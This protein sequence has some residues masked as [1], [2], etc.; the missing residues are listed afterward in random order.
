[1]YVYALITSPAGVDD[2]LRCSASSG[3]ALDY[4]K[5]LL[6]PATPI[7]VSNNPTYEVVVS[8]AKA[9]P[10]WDLTLGTAVGVYPD[11]GWTATYGYFGT[12]RDTTKTAGRT[13]FY[14]PGSYGAYTMGNISCTINYGPTTCPLCP[15]GFGPVSEYRGDP[16]AQFDY[17]RWGY[18]FPMRPNK[19]WYRTGQYGGTSTTVNASIILRGY[20]DSSFNDADSYILYNG[21]ITD[22]DSNTSQGNYFTFNN[23]AISGN[24]TGWR[25]YQIKNTSP[26]NAG[27]TCLTMNFLLSL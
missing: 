9:L 26:T 14:S 22:S 16:T 11:Y 19:I 7:L 5:V 15:N 24:T 4:A 8:L 3:T 21:P 18:N 13:H 2:I 25:Y 6:L 20:P 27:F 10:L 17:Y 23:P 1:V 12:F